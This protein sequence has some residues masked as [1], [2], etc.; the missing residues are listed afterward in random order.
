MRAAANPGFACLKSCVYSDQEKYLK[1]PVTLLLLNGPDNTTT[2][3]VE[4]QSLTASQARQAIRNGRVLALQQQ[5]AYLESEAK[6]KH[7][8]GNGKLKS[9][10]PYVVRKDGIVP[11]AGIL[12]TWQVMARLVAEH[13]A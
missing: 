2:L 5:R 11:D 12:L 4:V 10:T 9:A 1:T 6:K 13:T 7:L 8:E 3:Q